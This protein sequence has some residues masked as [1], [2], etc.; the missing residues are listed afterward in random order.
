MGLSVQLV[1]L[2]VN[3]ISAFETS[4]DLIGGFYFVSIKEGRH[5]HLYF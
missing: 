2:M 5:W 4:V 1:N 3:E